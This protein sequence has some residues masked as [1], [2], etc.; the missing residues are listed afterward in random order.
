MN[1]FLF[2]GLVILF[3][4]LITFG[5]LF[6]F[7]NQAP[8]I[9]KET[10]SVFPEIPEKEKIIS[11]PQILK[12]EELKN[13]PVTIEK[14]ILIQISP[15]PS[16]GFKPLKDNFL[17]YAE[18]PTGHIKEIDLKTGETKIISNTTIPKIFEIK[19]NFDGS[20]ILFKYLEEEEK[21]KEVS[22]ELKGTSTEGVILPGPIISW[23]YLPN[24]NDIFYYLKTQNNPE[25][26]GLIR[27]GF[28]NTNQR[29]IYTSPFSDFEIH[30]PKTNILSLTTRP[31]ELNPGFSYIY[32]PES[33]AFS[34]ILG[35]IQGLKIKWDEK[36]EKFIY[37]DSDLNLFQYN[38]K[39]NT[40][41]PLNFKGL[42][43]KC[44]FS[45]KSTNLLFCAKP[46]E[47]SS[48]L[49]PD[50]WHQGIK[51]FQ[52]EIWELNS[53]TGETKLIYNEKLFDVLEIEIS[54][55]DEFLYFQ[56]KSANFLFGLKLKNQGD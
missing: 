42:A 40:S 34:K 14:P 2:F 36:G 49:Y 39:K 56:D 26:F 23:G 54:A 28:K 47:I 31:S 9:E 29:E 21:I 16:S 4:I 8:F 50:E 5:V 52:D 27:A 32:N 18:K 43:Q 51:K 53:E 37:S 13:L 20:K 25:K 11:L 55:N 46:K 48:G 45:K 44:V 24:S 33:R 1:R 15:E 35:G 7:K 41:V 17:R 3:I 38:V 30:W 12:P 19:W 6:L 10:T 22:A